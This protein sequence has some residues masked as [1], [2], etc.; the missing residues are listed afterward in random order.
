MACY[1]CIDDRVVRAQLL[2]FVFCFCSRYVKLAWWSGESAVITEVS[3]YRTMQTLK[4]LSPV[5]T[6]GTIMEFFSFFFRRYVLGPF[7]ARLRT[8]DRQSTASVLLARVEQKRAR[9]IA[10]IIIGI[11]VKCSKPLTTWAAHIPLY[12]VTKKKSTSYRRC[13]FYFSKKNLGIL[14]EFLFFEQR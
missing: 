4:P 11:I 1:P 10:K 13:L 12:T 8:G 5:K 14:V 7:F 6:Y 2:T 3:Q 9:M